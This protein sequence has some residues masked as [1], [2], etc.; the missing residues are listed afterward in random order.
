MVL[1]DD[2]VDD[3]ADWRTAG[4]AHSIGPAHLS[5]AVRRPL[6]AVPDRTETLTARAVSLPG[7]PRS[8]PES[9]PTPD[10]LFDELYA[11]LRRRARGLRRRGAAHTLN[12]TGLVHEAYLKLR[13]H[14]GWESRE[15]FLNTAARAMRQVLVNAAEA[16]VAAK[17]GGGAWVVTLDERLGLAPARPEEILAL[18]EALGR[19]E[20][21]SARQARV[22]ECRYFAGL[23]V[24]ETATALGVGTATVQRDWR[25]ARAWLQQTLAADAATGSGAVAVG[26]AEPPGAASA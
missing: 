16:R 17:R 18:D 19:L 3:N 23:S 25:F 10:A 12:T 21:L 22:V 15:H 7:A 14:D 4:D 24:E 20:Q 8:R 13:G 5:V 11:A 2:D 1:V 9:L 6:L 26:A